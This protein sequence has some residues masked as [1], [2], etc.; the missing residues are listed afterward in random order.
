MPKEIEALANTILHDP[1]TVKVDPVTSTVSSIHQYVYL[2]DKG[3]K[4]RLLAKLLRDNGVG[5]A[6]VFTRTKHG[7]F[8]PG[9]GEHKQSYQRP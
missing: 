6:L 4:R 9:R 2:I 1:V 3:N 7:Q 8:F 5:S